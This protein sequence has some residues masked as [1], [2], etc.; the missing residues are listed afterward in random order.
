MASVL[1]L[2][3]GEATAVWLT[4]QPHPE[5]SPS[6]NAWEVDLFSL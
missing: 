3:D 2:A 4:A 1:V 5:E 6:S